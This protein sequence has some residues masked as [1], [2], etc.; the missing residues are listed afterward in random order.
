M[1]STNYRELDG[2]EADYQPNDGE[3]PRDAVNFSH[4]DVTASNS[5][6]DVEITV[7]QKPRGSKGVWIP[8][9]ASERIRVSDKKAGKNLRV[10][11]ASRRKDLD[12]DRLIIVCYEKKAAS[13]KKKA[14]DWTAS[15]SS[16]YVELKRTTQLPTP[17]G[18]T[19]VVELVIKVL[20]MYRT[21]KFHVT[22]PS[23]TP[24]V[25]PLVI[26]SAEFVTYN[27]GSEDVK[28]KKRTESKSTPKKYVLILLF[29]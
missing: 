5:I 22:I 7:K 25:T 13:S 19:Q 2:F 9:V 18:F 27:S 16:D 26:E 3:S 29:Q 6:A 1:E 17:A 20:V 21:V 15:P 24:S 23:F 11:V 10:V 8:L 4:L 14:S 28:K 12:L